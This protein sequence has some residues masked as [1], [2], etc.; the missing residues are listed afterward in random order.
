LSQLYLISACLKRF[1]DDGSPREDLPLLQW[2]CD[3]ALYQMQ[4]SLRGLLRNLP[5]RPL[6]TLLRFM[7]MPWG[8]S[9]HLPEDRLGHQ[10]ASL[11]LAPS[12]ARDRLTQGIFVPAG[13]D[14]ALGRLEAALH[15]VID[16]EA[17]ERMLRA[18]VKS[19]KLTKTREDEL[20]DRGLA[21]G[22]IEPQ[23][24]E[25]LKAAIAARREVIKVDDFS[26]DYW[27]KES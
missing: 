16:A 10:A 2:A 19:G 18:A 6:A 12:E 3:D 11:I 24:A 7:I 13:D 5:M 21:A 14:E 4:E 23:E 20:V 25:L 27:H 15:K 8:K 26:P 22:V 17:V 9:Y 1:H